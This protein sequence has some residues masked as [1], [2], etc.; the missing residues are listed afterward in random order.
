[1]T[2]LNEIGTSNDLALLKAEVETWFFIARILEWMSI[3]LGNFSSNIL[4]TCQPEL[5]GE[6][7]L[8]KTVS[9]DWRPILLLVSLCS[10][11]CYLRGTWPCP[12]LHGLGSFWRLHNTCKTFTAHFCFHGPTLS[13]CFCES[14]LMLKNSAEEKSSFPHSFTVSE[15]SWFAIDIWAL[16]L[17]RSHFFSMLFVYKC[18]MLSASRHFSFDCSTSALLHSCHFLDTPLWFPGL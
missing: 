1:M 17:S 3:A 9:E 6:V 14:A 2:S 12:S 18:F 10:Q 8:W 4:W 13:T 7:S 16:F 15:N 11:F 5:W